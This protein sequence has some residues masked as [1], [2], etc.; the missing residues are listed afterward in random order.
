M[1]TQPPR[2]D[3]RKQVTSIL[4]TPPSHYNPFLDLTTPGIR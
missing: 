3:K 1:S 4:R 2:S